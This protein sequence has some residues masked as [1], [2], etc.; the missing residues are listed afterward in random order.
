M[1]ILRLLPGSSRPLTLAP[2]NYSLSTSNSISLCTGLRLDDTRI[3]LL[4]GDESASVPSTPIGIVPSGKQTILF[5][6]VS[7]SC[8]LIP[9]L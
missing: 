9:L 2:S 5:L 6:I 1:I 7:L 4:A 8:S 3:D